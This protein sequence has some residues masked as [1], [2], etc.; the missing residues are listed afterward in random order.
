MEATC[1]S[2]VADLFQPSRSERASVRPVRRRRRF[3]EKC[4]SF[5]VKK[6]AGRE[7]EREDALFLQDQRVCLHLFAL[8]SSPLG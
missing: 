7:R 1:G 2:G 3:G 5:L 6:T 4:R 8:E